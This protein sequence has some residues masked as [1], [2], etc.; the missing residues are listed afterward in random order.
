VPGFRI[1]RFAPGH[2]SNSSRRPKIYAIV[3]AG[4]RQYRVEA[5]QVVD[6]DRLEAEIGATIELRDVLLLSS[7]NSTTVGTPRV[8]GAVILAEVLEHGRGAKIMVF[9]YKNKTRYRRRH[10]HRQDFTRLAIRD[11]VVDSATVKPEAEGKP[12]RAHGKKAAEPRAFDEASEAPP[13]ETLESPPAEADT[14]G[15]AT[16]KRRRARSAAPK[17]EAP[18]TKPR[19]R[20][21]AAADELPGSRPKNPPV[22]PTR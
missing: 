4:G 16:P 20:K 6:V 3:R 17:G 11:I 5:E 14:E 7:D 15:D 2:V 1:N 13:T 10:G 18:A 21:S 12:K 19:A 22:A 8:D 9:K